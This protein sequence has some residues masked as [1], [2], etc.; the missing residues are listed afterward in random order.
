MRYRKLITIGAVVAACSALGAAPALASQ[1]TA[2][3]PAV[4][5][6]GH[7]GHAAVVPHTPLNGAGCNVQNCRLEDAGGNPVGVL[8]TLALFRTP[9]VGVVNK[10]ANCWPF[11]DCRFD[12]LYSGNE[13]LQFV[14]QN[15][16]TGD[17]MQ[18][19][20]VHSGVLP[21]VCG[22]HNAGTYWMTLGSS[23]RGAC[24]GATFWLVNVGITNNYPVYPYGEAM[25]LNSNNLLYVQTNRAP[26]FDDQWCVFPD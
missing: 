19:D 24:T 15:G 6:A 12:T 16:F 22:S 9:V 5:S 25:F 11:S 10:T 17:C 21:G 20:S 13:V 2:A 8:G 3:H 18:T 23:S 1:P 7:P 26:G 14:L 4:A